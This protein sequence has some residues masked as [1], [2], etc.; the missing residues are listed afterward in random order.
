MRQQ[1]AA[2]YLGHGQ[3]PFFR[4]PVVTDVAAM[5]PETH[6]ALLG[7]PHDLGVT[8]QP[9][10]RLAPYHLRRVSALVQGYHPRHRLDVFAAT[11]A[12]DAGNVV[13]PPFDRGAM[14]GVVEQRARALH[15][16]GVA[17]LIVGGDHSIALP[18][19]RAAH[20]RYGR[21]AV[22]HV[23]AHF[24]TSGPEIWGDDYHH[25][26]P[27]RHAIAEGLIEHGQLH[28]VGMR[29]PWSGPD[30]REVALEHGARLY[31]VDEIAER[32]GLAVAS[33]IRRA[34]R[35]L[36]VY[37][38]FDID[39]LDPAFAP[40]TGTPSP[41]GIDARQALNL[42]RGLAGAR[43]VGMDLVEVCPALD[44]ADVTCHLG[45]SLL[46]EALALVAVW[47]RNV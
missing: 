13:F 27:L 14:R 26:T 38:T 25:G 6:A 2:E 24:D 40:G 19:L 43:L 7:V 34:V 8:Y 10:A 3:A 44:H 37:L 33:E 47:R 4:L 1:S 42:L 11:G 9:G 23:D 32:G 15:D 18:A 28:Q 30:E 41:G 46:F 29:G 45:V 21:L 12:V 16:R 20:G 39:A 36:P 17:P 5:P 31:E 22:V 35:D